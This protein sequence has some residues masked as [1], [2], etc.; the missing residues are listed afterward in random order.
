V[1]QRP[2]LAARAVDVEDGIDDCSPIHRRPASLLPFGEQVADD[3]IKGLKEYHDAVFIRLSHEMDGDWYPYSEG[4]KKDPLRNMTRDY[5]A[6]WRYVVDRFRKADVTNV[7][8][9]KELFD[10]IEATPQLKA[11]CWFQWGEEWNVERDPGQL[12]EYQH[13]IRAARYSVP[14]SGRQDGTRTRA[15]EPPQPSPDRAALAWRVADSRSPRP[16]AQGPGPS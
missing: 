8:W 5:V 9:V 6:Y 12:A 3:W 10:V 1:G 2:P 16:Q 15:S 4:Y 14:F 7:A 11:L 13:R